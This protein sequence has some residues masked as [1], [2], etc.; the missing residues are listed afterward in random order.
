MHVPSP[1]ISNEFVKL[2]TYLIL[3]TLEDRLSKVSI[4]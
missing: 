4:Q 1:E 2:I 3:E